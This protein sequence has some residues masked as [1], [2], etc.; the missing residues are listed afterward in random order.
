MTDYR[1]HC[2]EYGIP[3]YCRDPL[4]D[5]L[6]KGKPPGRFLTAVLEN[7]FVTAAS[8][9]DDIN[10]AALTAYARFLV[11]VAPPYVWGSKENVRRWIERADAG[12]YHVL[13]GR[14]RLDD[15]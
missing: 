3:D 2:R 6:T 7:D 12:H 13:P 1:F 15:V 9:A 14:G 10:A 8:C 4:C 5:Y 11:N